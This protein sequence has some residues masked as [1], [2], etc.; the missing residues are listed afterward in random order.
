MEETAVQDVNEKQA[1]K[2][3]VTSSENALEEMEDLEISGPKRT[4]KLKKR[5]LY[6]SEDS[7]DDNMG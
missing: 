1:Q 3:M 4:R 5:N 7:D 2:T 6:V